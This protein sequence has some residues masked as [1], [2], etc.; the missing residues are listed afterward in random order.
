MANDN[1]Q[2]IS[3]SNGSTIAVQGDD[4]NVS[5]V[6]HH[7]PEKLSLSSYLDQGS[8]GDKFIKREKLFDE[9]DN[10]LNDGKKAVIHA[11]GGTGK[12]TNAR[13]Y[14]YKRI[15]EGVIVRWINNDDKLIYAGFEEI[16]KELGIDTNIFKQ[17]L[18]LGK[19]QTSLKSIN[20]D[21]GSKF[22]FIFDNVQKTEDI[23]DY[24]QSLP[25]CVKIIITTR[26][27]DQLKNLDCKEIKLKPFS[28]GEVRRYLEDNLPN[29]INEDDFKLIKDKL[30]LR[31]LNLYFLV[32]H[33]QDEEP[34]QIPDYIEKVNNGKSQVEFLIEDLEK[35][36]KAQQM[37][38]YASYL[39]PDFINIEIFLNL[40]DIEKEEAKKYIKELKSKGL[41]EIVEDRDKNQGLK[42]HE[43]VQ[44]DTQ[45][46]I[47]NKGSIKKPE[48]LV[49]LLKVLDGLMPYVGDA[50]DKDWQEARKFAINAEKVVSCSQDI[51]K[52]SAIFRANLYSKLGNYYDYIECDYSSSKKNYEQALEMK[53]N[54]YK[55]NHPDI[56]ISLTNVCAAYMK[57]GYT[58]KAP[59]YGKQALE[60][61]KQV[62]EMRQNLYEGDHPDI[63]ARLNNVGHAYYQLGDAKKA[64]E[65]Y[66]QA[67]EM[68]QNLYE[69][70]HPSIATSLN[71]VGL[72]YGQLGDANKKA[73]EYGKQAL[74]MWQNLY[75]GNHPDIATNLDNVGGA[76]NSLGDAEKALE[77]CKQA[78]AMWQNLYEGDHPSI[79]GSLN[80]VG[81]AYGQLG[82]TKKALEYKKKA[83]EMKKRLS[84]KGLAD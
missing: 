15:K 40:L 44:E 10:I 17:D 77:Y 27:T 22:L 28:Q 29:K 66:E 45:N 9:I 65:Y 16:A 74:A 20:K 14:A 63:A 30:T 25:N 53:Q 72:A 69:G 43:I 55:G 26:D 79:A 18:M 19:V 76:Y 5:V 39:D 73:L 68:R 71:N 38:Y 75:E 82:D 67:L 81:V 1:T 24:I 48:I 47:A 8:L 60:Y 84:A 52:D 42:I 36:G 6:V 41:V 21:Y 4:N 58:K 3:T 70:D 59:E 83:E 78:L 33:I 35:D 31:P 57:L 46:Y 32:K 2:D 51:G 23:N 64:L 13:E 7:P 80:N 49:S 34:D 50:P 37:L 61:G 56:A 62:L 12:S 54:L 11:S